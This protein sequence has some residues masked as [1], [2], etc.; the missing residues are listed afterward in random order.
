MES[1]KPRILAT[2]KPDPRRA[3]R[4]FAEAME[5]VLQ[6]NDDKGGWGEEQCPIDYLET[7]LLEEFAEWE[8]ARKDTFFEP[9]DELLDIANFCMMLYHRYLD[10][11][12]CM[13]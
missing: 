13:K 5:G 6:A 2:S 1:N 4:E 8:K 3:V 9:V 11:K 12:S 7:R 10:N